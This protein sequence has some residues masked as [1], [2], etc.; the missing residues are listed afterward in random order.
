MAFQDWV[1]QDSQGPPTQGRL[2]DQTGSQGCLPVGS[3]ILPS[4]EVCVLLLERVAVEIHIPS[5]PSEQCT[6]HIHE[7]NEA[8]SS[9]LEETRYQS[10]PVPRWH[11]GH[12]TN[13]GGEK[14]PS[15]SLGLRDQHE[16]KCNMPR[17]GDG[18]PTLLPSISGIAGASDGVGCWSPVC[19]SKWYPEILLTQFQA[20]KQYRTI[21]TFRSAILMTHME[22][23][24]VR[25]G[26]HPLV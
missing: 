1:Y 13:K 22:V 16:E 5:F 10:H 19:T 17:L 25:V 15:H 4:Q 8:N 20:G 9:N 14:A 18:V 26:Q 21:N 7:T 3:V 11:A 23:D 24:A 2:D 12:G 6:F